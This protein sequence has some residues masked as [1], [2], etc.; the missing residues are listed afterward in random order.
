M[1]IISF[2][3]ISYKYFPSDFL[4][5]IIMM[6]CLVNDPPFEKSSVKSMTHH[7]GLL[8]TLTESL[9]SYKANKTYIIKSVVFHCKSEDS[10]AVLPQ[11]SF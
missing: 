3:P 5:L 6:T 7:L 9:A 4:L 1:C 8:F 11:H 10:D 2:P